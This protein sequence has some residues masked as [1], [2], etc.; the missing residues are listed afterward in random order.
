MDYDFFI[1]K[2]MF[3]LIA[4]FGFLVVFLTGLFYGYTFSE[5]KQYF[6]GNAT[7]IKIVNY[8]NT[9]YTYNFIPSTDERTYSGQLAGRITNIVIVLIIIGVLL[10]EIGYRGSAKYKYPTTLIQRFKNF[11]AKIKE[12]ELE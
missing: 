11:R 7:E 5:N 2:T 4:L 8:L 12:R 1:S 3:N 10:L 6:D 9:K